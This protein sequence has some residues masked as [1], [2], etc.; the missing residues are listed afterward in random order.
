MSRILIID[1]S[2]SMR[3]QLELSLAELNHT[4]VT[5]SNGLEA[6]HA[7]QSAGPFDLMIT[8]MFMPEMD[9]VE[10]IE[11]IQAIQPGIKII[12]ISGGGMGMS[13]A[14]M[15]D[16]ADGLGAQKSLPKPFKPEELRLAVTEALAA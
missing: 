15:L 4:L 11:R 3:A 7:V 14:A 1:D 6:V 8:D 10:A 13:G 2:D 9:G 12:A 5:A 16:I